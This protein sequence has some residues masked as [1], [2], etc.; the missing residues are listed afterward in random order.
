MQYQ[1]YITK[2]RTRV[3]GICG[4]V[5]IP[6]GTILPVEGGFITYK[7]RPLCAV[8]S[9][10]ARDHLWGYDPQNPEAE[11]KRQEAVALLLATAPKD[12]G[13]A[14]AAPGNPWNKYGHLE[15]TPEAWVWVW[16]PTVEDL[17][18]ATVER[19]LSCTRSG[20]KPWEVPEK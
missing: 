16:D 15:Q 7:G 9:K 12:T 13:D 3:D 1:Q 2:K 6:W 4:R 20:T 11:I 5:H 17:P 14:L 18:L 10:T 19:L 8:R